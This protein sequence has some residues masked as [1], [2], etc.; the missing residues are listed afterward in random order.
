MRSALITGAAGGIGLALTEAFVNASYHVIALDQ[1]QQPDALHCAHYVQADLERFVEDFSYAESVAVEI[2]EKCE[3]GLDVLVNNAALQ[4]LG[5]VDSLLREDWKRSL[6]VNLLAPFLLSQALLADIER[7]AGCIINISSIHARL[8]KKNFVAYATTKA[9]LSGMTR[10]M[11]VDLGPRVRVNA[12]EPAAVE[13]PM[14]IEGFTQQPELYQQLT[15]CHPQ[16]RIGKPLDVAELALALAANRFAFM[17]GACVS[18]DGGI[19]NRLF[20]PL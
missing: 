18:L 17:Q 2:K 14:L 8:T 5:G 6:D 16:Q 10:A 9:A 11:A 12:I 1:L 7:V 13:T 20:D 4:V 19:S 15:A 3:S